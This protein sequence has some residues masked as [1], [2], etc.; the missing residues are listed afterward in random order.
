MER[1]I[2]ALVLVCAACLATGA[3]S[4][5]PIPVVAAENVYGDLALQIG[6]PH[7]AVTSILSNPNQD[8]HLFEASISTARKLA[9]AAIVLCN[10]VDYDPWMAKLLGASSAAG[11]T[12]IVAGDLLKRQSGVNPHLWY[13]PATMPMMAASLAAA[14]ERRDPA[15]AGEYRMRLEAFRA[16]LRPL[17]AEIAAIR[18]AY[19]HVAVT[20][21]EPVFGY[22]AAA[23]GFAMRND[24]FQIAVMNDTDP[25][26]SQV[27]GFEHDLK[28]GAVRIL[29]YNDQ[30][31][32]D[33]T[34]RLLGI[35]RAA[36]VPVVG[37]SETEPQGKTYQQW[38]TGA[39]HAT[40]A[41]LAGRAS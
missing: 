8:P 41:A 19:P 4:A 18:H 23:L 2:A 40:E 29:Y 37:V 11:R 10:G 15:H 3:A 39:L 27:A 24:G 13:D 25:S 20:A 17:D 35:A 9:G 31:T 34:A 30:V 28:T 21:T 1:L 33:L 26:P 16:S 22:M 7:V 12:V 6:G 38:M 36:H 5:D 32:D 14:L